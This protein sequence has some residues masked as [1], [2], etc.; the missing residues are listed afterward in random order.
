MRRP[1]LCHHLLDLPTAFCTA[2]S[3]SIRC[4]SAL[5]T[6][7]RLG[8]AN[9]AVAVERTDRRSTPTLLNTQP[10]SS[11]P[12]NLMATDLHQTATVAAF[13]GGSTNRQQASQPVEIKEGE[14]ESSVSSSSSLYVLLYIR[15]HPKSNGSEP[16]L[17]TS[18]HGYCQMPELFILKMAAR[19]AHFPSHLELVTG[20]KNPKAASLALPLTGP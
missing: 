14:E 17:F 12:S 7:E 5:V 1:P 20:H 9:P 16:I 18:S 19:Q 15:I 3:T 11:P 8:N 13:T 6:V 2:T 10:P 4:R